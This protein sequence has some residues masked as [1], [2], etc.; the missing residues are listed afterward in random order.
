MFLMEMD[1]TRVVRAVRGKTWGYFVWGG[2][3]PA[4]GRT[5]FCMRSEN[6]SPSRAVK[7]VGGCFAVREIREGRCFGWRESTDVRAVCQG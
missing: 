1:P 7:V 6:K 2:S 5:K 4:Q 3:P